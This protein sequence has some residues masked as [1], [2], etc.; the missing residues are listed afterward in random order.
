MERLLDFA[1]T[2]S[3]SLSYL[4]GGVVVVVAAAVVGASVTV[5]DLVEWA[6][7]IFGTTFLILL[8]SLTYI[9]I[10]CLQKMRHEPSN[11]VW[12]EGGMQAASGITTLAL[13]YTLMGISLGIGSLAQQTL[14][15]ETV[16][17]VIKGL[18]ANFSLAFMTTVVGL[19]L[20]AVL[21]TLLVLTQARR[22][23]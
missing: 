10:Y 19:P 21:R 13:T 16:Q 7:R 14:T 3:R 2:G 12:F 17:D 1:D 15:P 8:V 11:D 5:A 23:S 18:T 6:Q 22:I 4:L 9:T 20:A